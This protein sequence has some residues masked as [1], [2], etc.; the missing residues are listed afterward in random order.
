MEQQGDDKEENDGMAGTVD[1][2]RGMQDGACTTL[3]EGMNKRWQGVS[4]MTTGD[5][6]TMMTWRQE[7]RGQRMRDKTTPPHRVDGTVLTTR[8]GRVDRHP[9]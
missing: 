5:G 6:G 1:D 4:M 8:G 3:R 2:D 7:D 9:Q